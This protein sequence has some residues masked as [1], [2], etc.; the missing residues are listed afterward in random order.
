MIVLACYSG[1][2]VNWVFVCVCMCVSGIFGAA[3][4]QWPTPGSVFCSWRAVWAFSADSLAQYVRKAQPV[5]RK[6]DRM[7]RIKDR[8]ERFV[9]KQVCVWKERS[10]LPSYHF[11]QTRECFCVHFFYIT[12]K[13]LLLNLCGASKV[14]VTSLIPK[15]WIRLITCLPQMQCKLYICRRQELNDRRDEGNLRANETHAHSDIQE[16]PQRKCVDGN[17]CLSINIAPSFIL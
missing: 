2:C 13:F 12:L 3:W 6:E 8:S 15:E 14:R 11:I 4:P 5:W 16:S 17:V 9:Y 7:R 10:S 1:V